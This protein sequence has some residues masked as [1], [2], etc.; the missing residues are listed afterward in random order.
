M[1]I[2]ILKLKGKKETV[3]RMELVQVVKAIAQG[4]YLG[5]VHSLR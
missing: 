5:E 3:T 2:T 1:K 4:E